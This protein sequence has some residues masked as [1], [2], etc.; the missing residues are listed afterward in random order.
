VSSLRLYARLT[1]GYGSA[2]AAVLAL[3]RVL[4]VTPLSGWFGPV[5]RAAVVAFQEAHGLPGTGVVDGATWRA[6][7]A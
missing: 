4:R 3:Q 7:G 1:I 5:T 2:G 6:L